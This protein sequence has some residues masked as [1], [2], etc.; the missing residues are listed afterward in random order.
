[1]KI[2]AIDPATKTGFARYDFKTGELVSDVVSF[3]TELGAF[4]RQFRKWL[5]SQIKGFGITDV[6]I[7]AAILPQGNTNITALKKAY[8][9]N[10]NTHDIAKSL[11]CSLTEVQVG[12]WRSH[13][14]N[15]R[16]VPKEHQAAGKKSR[17]LKKAVIERCSE[18]GWETRD[19]NEADS[20][21]I[22][23]WARAQLDP[24]Y[25]VNSTPLFEGI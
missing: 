17:W 4:N 5:L 22:L 15:G 14:L 3:D 23:D 6:V 11:G 2:L 7:E 24:T 1:M 13:F 8:A 10:M 12:S 21:G 25:A 19:N 18:R 16:K 20:L 9:I